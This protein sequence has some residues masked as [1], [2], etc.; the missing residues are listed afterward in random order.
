M[1]FGLLDHLFVAV[2]LGLVFPLFGWWAHRRFL[3]RLRRDG[4]AALVREYRNTLIWLLCLGLAVTGLWQ[5]GGRAWAALGF[6][7]PDLSGIAAGVGAGALIGLALRPLLI[8]RSPKA[9]AAIRKSFGPLEA[10]LPRDGQQLRWAWLVSIF[11]GVFEEI[12]YRGYLM[13]Y[14]GAWS[15]PWGALAASSLLFGFAHL[16]QGKAGVLVTAILGALFG[17]LYLQTGSLLLPILLHA[18]LDLSQMTSAWLVLRREPS[19]AA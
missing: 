19:T 16:Y 6:A 14:F 13:A 1:S 8:A 12:A 15:G 9:Q 10:I 5:L 11:A 3:E 2:A 18:A 7:S 17:W 4:G